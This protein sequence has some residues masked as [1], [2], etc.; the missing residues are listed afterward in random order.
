M[1][2]APTT[3]LCA[4]HETADALAPGAP[5]LHRWAAT[6]LEDRGAPDTRWPPHALALVLH[7]MVALP[8]AA[9]FAPEIL[10]LLRTMA[11]HPQVSWLA[12]SALRDYL[13][14]GDRWAVPVLVDALGGRGLLAPGPAMEALAVVGDPAAI[15][16][17]LEIVARPGHTLAPVAALALGR[18]GAHEAVPALLALLGRA[19]EPAVVTALGLLRA[20]QAAPVLRSMLP[21]LL[22]TV[23]AGYLGRGGADDALL[24]AVAHAIGRIADADAASALRPLLDRG[25]SPVAVAAADALTRLG[26][27]GGIAV[28]RAHAHEWDAARRLAQL[29]LPD[30]AL[31]LR[32]C[33]RA[34]PRFWPRGMT[35]D[36]RGRQQLLRALGYAGEED[37]LLF[38]AWVAA[39]DDDRTELGWTLAEEARRAARRIAMRGTTRLAP[40]APRDACADALTATPP[41]APT[42]VH[43]THAFYAPS[44]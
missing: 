43:L 8:D 13:M 44:G 30:G 38:L 7:A 16:P 6:E 31:A 40:L 11:P 37:D 25:H 18:L 35:R 28:L 20:L 4:L 36:A 14:P 21:A 34:D 29:D 2:N 39:H 24:V 41:D 22:R 19:R 10:G 26:D 1:A 33:Y 12:A 5:I 42:V 15:P 9:R 23:G 27:A 17:L 3:M 32:A